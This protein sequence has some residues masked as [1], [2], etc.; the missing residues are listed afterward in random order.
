MKYLS[1][2]KSNNIYMVFFILVKSQSIPIHALMLKKIEDK[3]K[4]KL[5]PDHNNTQELVANIFNHF[6]LLSIKYN[7]EKENV[8][9]NSFEVIYISTYL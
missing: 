3:Q 1:S 8:V 4:T 6:H 7:I 5:S 2:D 9:F